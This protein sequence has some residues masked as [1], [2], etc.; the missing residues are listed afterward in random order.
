MN[1]L[2]YLAATLALTSTVTSFAAEDFVRQTD[3][4]S[5]VA[6][7]T[8]IN[9]PDGVGSTESDFF[10]AN[11]VGAS[12]AH[13]ELYGIG[14]GDDT[15]LYL[16]DETVTGAHIPSGSVSLS[17]IDPYEDT[18]RTRA[19]FAYKGQFSVT[20]I[21]T[22]DDAPLSSKYLYF[23]RLVAEYPEGEERLPID[24]AGDEQLRVVE[25]FFINGNGSSDVTEILTELDM[26][27]D[28]EGLPENYTQKGE[29][30]IRL[31]ALPNEDLGWYVLS[32]K[33][34]Y[35]WPLAEAE[36]KVSFTGDQSD[37]RLVLGTDET[38]EVIESTPTLFV[39]ATD[40]YPLSTSF[41]RIYKGGK[42]DVI[43]SSQ[44]ISATMAAGEYELSDYNTVVPQT[45][46]TIV[47][48]SVL[49]TILKPGETYTIELVTT[50]PFATN[51]T[52]TYITF[53]MKEN[54]INI[55]TNANSAE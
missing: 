43:T 21:Q 2:K 14:L 24:S 51:E 44:S 39:T 54:R 1:Y 41:L 26:R 17:S 36:I 20:N 7:D 29:E 6:M 13:Y 55:N 4:A 40:L 22:G 27:V 46:S 37:A 53:T 10:G 19:D 15:N 48:A 8:Y 11:P 38:P 16:L 31:Y 23:E 42:T 12:G 52:V 3:L 32:E 5:G 50:T 45:M 35:V 28:S 9:G 49:E 18:V 33:K 25:S 30:R 47:D 34:V